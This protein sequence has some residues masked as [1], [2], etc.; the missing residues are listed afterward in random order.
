MLGRYRFTSQCLDHW[1]LEFLYRLEARTHVDS[2][3]AFRANGP[4]IYLAQGEALGKVAY[5][6][7]RAK[8]PA[9]N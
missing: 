3:V 9:G 6:P 5:Q 1:T 2:I 8:G 4:A 7:Y